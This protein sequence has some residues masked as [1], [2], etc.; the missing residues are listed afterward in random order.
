MLCAKLIHQWNRL[1]VFCMAVNESAFLLY[2]FRFLI[3]IVIT[4]P[5]GRKMQILEG[6]TK[7]F[8]YGFGNILVEYYCIKLPLHFQL[9]TE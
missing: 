6:V 5:N 1:I 9:N 3:A 4:A 2:S 7:Y 8:A